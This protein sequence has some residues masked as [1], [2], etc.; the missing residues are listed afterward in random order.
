MGIRTSSEVFADRTY[1]DDGSLTPR[2]QPN[3]SIHDEEQSLKQ[4]LQMIKNGK[5]IS[6]A[7]NEISITAETICLHGDGE[8][9]VAFAKSIYNR[10]KAE[11]IEMKAT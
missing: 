8:N 1:Q 5:V 2:T 9:A 11:N 4:V 6:T 3:A 7:G 10:L